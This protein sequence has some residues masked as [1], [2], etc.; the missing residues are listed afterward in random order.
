[1]GTKQQQLVWFDG[2]GSVFGGHLGSKALLKSPNK[3]RHDPG[4]MGDALVF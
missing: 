4:T 2:Q 3:L 1:M